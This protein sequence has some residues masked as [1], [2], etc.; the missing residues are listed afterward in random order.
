M[1][2]EHA[3]ARPRRGEGEVLIRHCHHRIEF[4]TCLELQKRVWGAADI[5]VV[6]L[7]MFVVAADTG[8]QV[9]GAFLAE[10]MVGFTMAV[11]GFRAGKVFLHSHMTAVLSEYRDCGI[12]R[13]LKLFQRQD[14]LSRG[15]DRVEWTFD[16]LELKNAYFNLV[17]LG[18][19]VRRFLPNRYGITTSPVHSGLPTDRLLAEW[20]LRS[21]RVEAILAG[22]SVANP[23]TVSGAASQERPRIRVPAEMPK[24]KQNDPV[25]AARVQSE[26]RWHFEH[27]LGRGY[28]VTEI[29]ISAHGGDYILQSDRQDWQLP[30]GE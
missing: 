20:E 16:P 21:P 14:A 10:R 18:A 9:L 24:L 25:E 12:G 13:Q 15:I 17:R 11:A 8:G 26:I 7:P 6:P 19:V 1:S 28:A 27:W 30:E 4:E 5:E 3:K 29:E 22:S 2:A 23:E